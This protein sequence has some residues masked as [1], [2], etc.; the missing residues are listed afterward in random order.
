MACTNQPT[1]KIIFAVV[2][3]ELGYKFFNEDMIVALISILS[4]NKLTQNEF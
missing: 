1:L 4:N 2:E 3:E